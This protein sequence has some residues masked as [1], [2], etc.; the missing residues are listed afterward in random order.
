MVQSS[1]SNY[2]SEFTIWYQFSRLIRFVNLSSSFFKS[3][4]GYIEYCIRTY[5]LINRNL[6]AINQ[7][8]ATLL[9]LGFK[10]DS[11]LFS[12]LGYQLS[13]NLLVIAIILVHTK[14]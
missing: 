8:K 12:W 10:L 7:E 1:L 4:C 3:G 13:G 9:Q 6:L 14:Y 2:A 11:L 5:S